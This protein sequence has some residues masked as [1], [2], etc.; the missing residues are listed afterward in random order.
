[1][2]LVGYLRVSTERQAEEGFGL[3]AQEAAVRAWCKKHGHKLVTLARDQGVSGTVSA[4]ERPGLA[5]A[6]SLVRTGEA[7]GLV[8]ARLDRLARVLTVQEAALSVVWRHGGRVFSAD[9][10]E[11]QQDDPDDPMRTFVRQVMGAAA[12]LERASLLARMNGGR[13]AKAAAG[14]YAHGAPRLGY[15]AEG[16]ELVPDAAEQHLVRHILA[17]HARGESVRAIAR[18]L[19]D[20][21][22]RTKQG[23]KWHPTTVA[24]VIQRENKP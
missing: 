19:D 11:V 13:K 2:R 3:P 23:G 10:G 4:E 1:M 7:E 15:R 16:G 8:V 24:R 14:R 12:Q 18:H 22:A 5:E 9:S 20:T 6:L 21:G 17:L